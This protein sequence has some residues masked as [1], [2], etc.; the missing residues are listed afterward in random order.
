MHATAIITPLAYNKVPRQFRNNALLAHNQE[1]DDAVMLEVAQIDKNTTA[2]AE[3]SL[4]WCLHK[5]STHASA[6]T[7][8]KL[9]HC[10]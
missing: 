7:T 10:I 5:N 1:G 3:I 8:L 2:L 4:L 9:L 6:A